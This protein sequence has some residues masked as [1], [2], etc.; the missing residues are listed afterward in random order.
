MI[1][2]RCKQYSYTQGVT[3]LETIVAVSIFLIVMVTVTQIFSSAIGANR[4]IEAGSVVEQEIRRW[5][6]EI[7][8]E[9]RTGEIDYE[10]Y[11][12]ALGSTLDRT[13]SD[14]LYIIGRGGEQ[15]EFSV[16]D[17]AVVVYRKKD[18]SSEESYASLSDK[19]MVE[20]IRFYVYPFQDP[21]ALSSGAYSVNVQPRVTIVATAQLKQPIRSE[22]GKVD[23]QTTLTSRI[24]RR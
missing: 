7:S 16:K 1:G 11:Q 13:G 20:K 6:D 22:E 2:N 8:R 17:D 3:L 5:T 21:F 15:V 14:T 12:R 23:F 24:L 10:R 4:R 19:V 9:L 18:I